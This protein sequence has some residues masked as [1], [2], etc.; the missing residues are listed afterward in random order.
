MRDEL[1][2]IFG[3]WLVLVRLLFFLQVNQSHRC[4]TLDK[5]DYVIDTELL[6][7][8]SSDDAADPD[9]ADILTFSKVSGPAWLSV[10]SDGTLS[11]TPTNA[12]VGL[13]SWIVE[14]NDGNSGTDTT[15]V[16]VTVDSVFLY[17]DVAIST[18]TVYG[19]SS[20]SF[21]DTHIADGSFQ[22]VTE[23]LYQ[24][25]RRSRLEQHWSFDITGDNLE[26]TFHATAG[27]TS[28]S[29]TFHFEYNTND[30]TGWHLLFTL[31][32]QS[33]TTYSAILSTLISDSVDVRVYDTDRSYRENVTD[34]VIVDEMYFLS[35]QSTAQPPRVTISASDASAS[36]NGLDSGEFMIF[37]ADW[38]AHA[39][40]ITVYFSISGSTTT[41]DYSELMTGSVLIVAGQ[42]SVS[43]TITPVDDAFQEGTEE[44]TLTLIADTGYTLTPTDNAT[45]II[46]DNDITEFLT[47]SESNIY[48]T[49][50]GDFTATHSDD[51]VYQ[52]LTEE[53]Y[54]GGNKKSRLE[55][56]WDYDL[57]GQTS[58]EFVLEAEHLSPN[59]PDDF[60]LQYS[61]DDGITWINLATVVQDGPI[62]TTVPVVLSPNTN[63]VTVRVIDTDSSNDRSSALLQIDQLFFRLP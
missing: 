12:D 1:F 6:H 57:T 22:I 37:L 21:V 51:A 42:L 8:V 55:H 53:R 3:I 41:A 62:L 14:V 24:K 15:T 43:L 48:G 9:I 63:N 18:N 2:I 5:I 7:D 11:G 25:N 30:G 46:A 49:V 33:M 31:S 44:I 13:N 36:E 17:R 47:I 52:T 27:H 54:T 59:D 32:S 10:A 61:E 40:D 34:A 4:N 20:G 45:V 28:S 16:N 19:T 39:T 23:E 56:R 58:L 50:S 26:V 60:L 35:E 29:E 38:I